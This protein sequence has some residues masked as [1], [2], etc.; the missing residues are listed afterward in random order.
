MLI[1]SAVYRVLHSAELI[2]V[3]MILAQ[4]YSSQSRMI[5]HVSFPHVL[6]D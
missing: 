1:Q 6:L 5:K 4:Y 3:I 2:I